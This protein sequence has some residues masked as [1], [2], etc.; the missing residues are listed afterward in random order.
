M[1]PQAIE[2]E[3][4]E[5]RVAVIGGGLAG[6]TA[7]YRLHR[8]GHRVSLFESGTH[9][10]GQIRT[11]DLCG[12]PV[13]VGAE[14]MHLHAPALAALV[15][16]AGLMSSVVG[17]NAGT[18]W[19]VTRKGLK[20]L[21][22]GVGPTGPTRLKPVVASG[23]LTPLQ[24]LRAAMEPVMA[25]RIFAEDVSVGR[26]TTTRFGSAVTENFVDP[27]LGTLHAGD[28]NRLSL[29]AT[30][31]QLAPM[32]ANGTSLVLRKPRPALPSGKPVPM[33]ASWPSGLSTL[34]TALAQD[35]DVRRGTRVTKL[36]RTPT[37]WQVHH[38]G[39]PTPAS[40]VVIT[41]PASVSGPLL[42]P[43]FPG[44]MA[45]L[46]QTRVADVSCT[47]LAYRKSDAAV[48]AIQQ[49][50]GILLNSANQ[51]VMKAA[52]F[53]SRKWRH[54]NHPEVFLIRASCGR[55]GSNVLDRLDDDELVDQIHSELAS[56]TGIAGR[57]VASLV[58]R[59]YDTYPQ[60]EVGH[61]D[62]MG[63]IRDRLDDSGIHLA[64]TAYDGI[65]MPSSI[66]SA[67]AAAAKAADAPEAVAS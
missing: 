35:L 6:L 14:A 34:T 18:S 56:L 44:I 16:E 62:R 10:G 50:N 24:L 57:P 7:A 60:L 39:G 19:L 1:I 32:A 55:A 61:L 4:M 48:P 21:P 65:G 43:H 26:F 59:W 25:R 23:I 66:R 42:E 30:A 45:Q 67:E 13:D 12:L 11:I 58:T 52:T 8:A 27:L 54:M 41:T 40:R 53:L 15:R 3:T 9:V 22:A 31:P 64:G 49:A 36:S 63:R 28:V 38:E 20:R 2:S 33:F 51:G 37:G 46:G 17:A 29:H 5:K 47:V